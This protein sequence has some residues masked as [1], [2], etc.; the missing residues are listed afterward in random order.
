MVVSPKAT[1]LQSPHLESSTPLQAGGR[2][3]PG[4]K[5]SGGGGGG[6]GAAGD[7]GSSDGV[8]E[9]KSMCLTHSEAK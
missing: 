6:S 9:H 2:C 8:T 5:N 4:K 7:G 1:P 3:P